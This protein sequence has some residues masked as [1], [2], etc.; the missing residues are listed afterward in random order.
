MSFTHYTCV[1][2]FDPATV[3]LRNLGATRPINPERVAR[4][5]S[6]YPVGASDAGP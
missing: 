2:H 6:E 1:G 4:L 3:N 5:V